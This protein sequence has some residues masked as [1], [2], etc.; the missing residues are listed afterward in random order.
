MEVDT[1]A[2][3]SVIG[4]DTF[5]ALKKKHPQLKLN[6]TK[7][8]LHTYTGEQV[9]VAGQV[10]M[11]VKYEEQEAVLPALVIQGKG[12]NLIG[13]NWLQEIKLNWRNI[14]QLNKGHT[15]TH[16]VEELVQKYEQVFQKGLGTFTGTMAKIHV[17]AEAKPIYCKARPVPYSL[18]KK[19]EEELRRLQAEG[20]VEP[21]QFAEWAAPIV[22][23][24]KVDKSIG[25]C[26]EYKVTVNQA[27]KLDNYPIPKAEDVFATLNGGDKFSKLDMSR[28]YQQI[29]LEDQS[30]KFTTINTHKGLFQFNRLPYGVSSSQGIFQRTIENLLQGIPFVVVR[31]DDILVSGS[32]DEEHLANLEEV[33]RRLSEAG[34]GVVY[35]GQK[36]NRQGIQPIEEKVRAITE[37]PTP[38]NES[39]VRSY[40]RMMKYYQR[41]LPNLSTIL[42]PLHG[43]LE[44]G[45]SWKWTAEHQESFTNSK[46]LSKSSGLLVHYDSGRICYLLAMHH[47]MI[48]GWCCHIEWRTILNDQ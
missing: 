17:A 8:R 35:L 30:K 31:V 47:R 11:S 6:E 10:K 28:A 40:L 1:G 43:L 5:K 7:V 16:R 21:V 26:G 19:V 9:K 24:V 41:Y 3:M 32:N 44:K 29:P 37:A 46:E 20:T 22:P 4:E 27:V 23:I 42:A 13:R 36:I 34:L 25:I 45:K 2:A 33:L 48:W 14:F 38:K 18:K 39:E 12:P 15:N